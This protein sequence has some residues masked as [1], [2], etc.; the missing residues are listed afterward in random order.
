MRGLRSMWWAALGSALFV[1]M[2]I[3]FFVN[4]K[5]DREIGVIYIAVD[6]KFETEF[7]PVDRSS[8]EPIFVFSPSPEIVTAAPFCDHFKRFWIKKALA[9]LNLGS[10]PQSAAK[11]AVSEI[12]EIKI[13]GDVRSEPKTIHGR[14]EFVG[15]CIPAILPDHPEVMSP[16]TFGVIE[17]R[18]V[19]WPLQGN[20]SPLADNE[21]LLRNNC[22]P[23]SGIG[24]LPANG[25]GCLHIAGLPHGSNSGV[26]KLLFAGAPQ[27][28]SR[29]GQ[30]SGENDKPESEKGDGIGRRPLPDGFAFFALMAGLLGGIITFL[31]FHF[32]RRIRCLPAEYSNPKQGSDK[33]TKRDFWV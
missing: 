24:G 1:E 5:I 3:V 23:L 27:H 10:G 6:L 26:P 21:C 7:D 18:R 12:M 14:R 30:S 25:D 9:S 32:G 2:A 16:K 15:L 28:D 31:L 11:G 19:S 4:A 29:N 17:D 33:E 8:R 20:I 13:V 22:R